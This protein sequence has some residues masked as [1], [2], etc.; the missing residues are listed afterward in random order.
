L[1]CEKYAHSLCVSRGYRYILYYT[2]PDAKNPSGAVRT[3][4]RTGLTVKHRFRL[5]FCGLRFAYYLISEAGS[6]AWL[7]GSDIGTAGK[8]AEREYGRTGAGSITHFWCRCGKGGKAGR[9]S[10]LRFSVLRSS[11]FEKY[12]VT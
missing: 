4:H 5:G 3:E 12:A 9:F 8:L 2:P 7:Q 1:G 11:F 10:V 6:T